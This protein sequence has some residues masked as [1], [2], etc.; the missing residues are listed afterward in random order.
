MKLESFQMKSA[1]QIS[2]VLAE[3]SRTM[4]IFVTGLTRPALSGIRTGVSGMGVRCANKYT[5][6]SNVSR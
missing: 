2:L 6:V 5:G 4:L 3:L 1:N